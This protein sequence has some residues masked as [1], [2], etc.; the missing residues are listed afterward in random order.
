MAN[1]EEETRWIH[2]DS[3]FLSGHGVTYNVNVIILFIELFLS[4]FISR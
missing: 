1:N 3:D 2:S 4:F